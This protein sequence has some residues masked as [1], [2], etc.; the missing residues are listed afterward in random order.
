MVSSNW[1]PCSVPGAPSSSLP[2]CVSCSSLLPRLE[3]P[4]SLPCCGLSWVCSCSLNLHSLLLFEWVHRNWEAM[5]MRI[6][7][8]RQHPSL[9]W[10]ILRLQSHP[11][12]CYD[13]SV[14]TVVEG[15]FACWF[16]IPYFWSIRS[17]HGDY[18]RRAFDPSPT[19]KAPSSQSSANA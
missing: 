16:E 13:G 11:H 7:N 17:V 5:L 1:S 18:H 4:I 9:V 2:L 3:V 14:R 19:L 8:S 6:L 15:V 10:R 12:A